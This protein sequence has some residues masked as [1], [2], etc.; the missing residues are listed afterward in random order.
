MCE[1]LFPPNHSQTCQRLPAYKD[2]WCSSTV[3]LPRFDCINHSSTTERRGWVPALSYTYIHT[4][5]RPLSAHPPYHHFHKLVLSVCPD[6]VAPHPAPAPAA[7]AIGCCAPKPPCIPAAGWGGL[8]GMPHPT[9]CW[10]CC[11]WGIAPG[12]PP[13]LMF[14]I[15]A[16]TYKQS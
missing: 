16:W 2:L 15:W 8:L 6:D 10:G 1:K 13:T 4:L 12:A 7:P 9:G 11:C 14:C 3:F 5:H